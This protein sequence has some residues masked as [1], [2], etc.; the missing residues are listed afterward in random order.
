MVF[1]DAP[2]SLPAHPPRTTCFPASYVK[3]ELQP[4]P[5]KQRCDGKKLTAL[6]RDVVN[7]PEVVC[8]AGGS[9]LAQPYSTCGEDPRPWK[10]DF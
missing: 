5:L 3:S 4:A 1:T 8:P 10:T 2:R 6:S 9:N 7:L